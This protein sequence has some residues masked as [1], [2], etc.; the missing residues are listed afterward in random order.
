[1][2]RVR[3]VPAVFD[4]LDSIIEHLRGL[5]NTRQGEAP[6]VPD[7]GVVDF[8]DLVHNF[9]EAIQ[10][11]QRCI[12]TTILQYEPRLKN[13]C[14]LLPAGGLV[15]G[16]LDRREIDGDITDFKAEAGE[17]LVEHLEGAAVTFAEG[18]HV[19]ARVHDRTQGRGDGV[20]AAG[21][22]DT[23]FGIFE[24]HECFFE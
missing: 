16:G 5:L 15:D 10:T 20:H 18:D 2:A 3:L 7:F 6:A 1:M 4:D 22:G 24:S 11:L 8:T 21:C 23:I 19:I 14:L 13:V 12:R 17:V 9:P